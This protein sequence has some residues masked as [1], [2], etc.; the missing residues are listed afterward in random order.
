[1]DSSSDDEGGSE[2]VITGKFGAMKIT[3]GGPGK[4]KQ[5]LASESLT[6]G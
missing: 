5:K 6:K 1:M 2:Y 4:Q 3:G